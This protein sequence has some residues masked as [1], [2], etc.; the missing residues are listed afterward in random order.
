MVLELECLV[1][2]VCTVK[3][4]LPVNSLSGKGVVAGAVAGAELVAAA[5]SGAAAG[6]E[7]VGTSASDDGL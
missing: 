1:K 2:V 7:L 4:M 5:A 3:A 6:A